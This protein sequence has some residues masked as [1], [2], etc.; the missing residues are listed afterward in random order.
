[1]GG[2]CTCSAQNPAELGLILRFDHAPSG[3]FVNAMETELGAILLPAGLQ[4]RW[5]DAHASP[6]AE[7]R[8]DVVFRFHGSCAASPG[9]PSERS[10]FVTLAETR[11]SDGRILPYTETDCDRLRGFLATAQPSPAGEESR[12]GRAMG[13][14]LAHELYH[15][16][17]QTSRHGNE[18][19][20]KAVHTPAAL[21]A[22][23]LRFTDDEIERIRSVFPAK[24]VR[25][26]VAAPVAALSARTAGTSSE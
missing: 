21:L 20:A 17:L 5:F 8:Q 12:L 11:V 4:L 19:I 15:F 13:R 23:S 1:M 9:T 7:T 18:G 25:R 26:P 3:V 16:L 24:T 14:L 2:W 10:D 22:R 6:G